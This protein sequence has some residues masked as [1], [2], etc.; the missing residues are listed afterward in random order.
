MWNG[1]KRLALSPAVL[2]VLSSTAAAQEDQAGMLSA[3]DGSV[4]AGVGWVSEDSFQF[5]EYT[6][7]D[8]SGPYFIGNVEAT[9][10]AP[11]DGDSTAYFELRGNN[12]GLDSRS[13]YLEGGRQGRFS[14]YGEYDAIPHLRFD[15]GQTPFVGAGSTDLTLP[16]GWVQGSDTAGL[17]NL[18][19]SLR[20]VDIETKRERI[21]AG[22]KVNLNRRWE[23]STSFRT[24]EKTGIDA[25]AGIFGTSGASFRSS[26]L[27]RPIDYTMREAGITFDYGGDRLQAQL[28]YNLSMFDDNKDSLTWENPWSVF[29]NATNDAQG[30]LALEPDNSAHH[31]SVSAGYRLGD[32]T[33]LTGS[34]TVGRMLQDDNFLP[35]TIRSDLSVPEPLPRASLDGEVD[36][37]HATVA[38]TTRPSRKADLKVGYTYDDRDN[39]TPIDTYLTVPNDTINQGPAGGIRARVNRPYSK[40]SH[41]VEL[42]AGYRVT[43]DTKLSASYDFEAASREL[44]EVEDTKEHT[45]GA[46]VRSS[47]AETASGSI[48]YAYSTR[49][50]SD[51]VSNLP[52]LVGHD[53]QYL[54]PPPPATPPDTYEQ[55]PYMR[56]FYM[57]DRQSH[58]VKGGLSWF[59]NDRLTMGLNGSYDRSE[60]DATIG[61]TG[62]SYLSGTVDVGYM[63]TDTVSITGYVTLERIGFQQTG[64]ERGGAAIAPNAPLDPTLFWDED[65]T[66]NAY[67][68]GFEIAVPAIAGA[69]DIVFDGAY[70][71]STIAY[72]IAAGSGTNN[73]NPVDPLPD[74]KS[75]L[76]SVGI[77]GDYHATDGITLRLGLRYESFRVDD[78][79]L[80]GVDEVIAPGAFG[81]GNGEPEYDAIIAAGSV[82]V[83]F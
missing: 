33:R 44:E 25:I 53:D 69:L 32:Q 63:P 78:F 68:A 46:K 59:P 81:L 39:Q 17:T 67:T 11:Y 27:P 37:I 71:K 60:Y 26:I 58:L 55:N 1:K 2:F 21:G 34:L 61:L 6:G 3:F 31:L 76:F 54:N 65:S 79:A 48:S 41:K 62:S 16:A 57:S 80:A 12:L 29:Q 83:N 73:G 64:Y 43:A 28:A 56:K 49:I 20:D 18:N 9:M 5:G 40:Q 24:E 82:V 77:R 74:L 70:S 4:E 51:Y 47:F 66:E 42:E 14:I 38:A 30:R 15:D 22:L 72:D 10:R 8:E 52:F 75:E 35:Y 13:V 23:L 50:G 36:T 19:A 7:L 45:V